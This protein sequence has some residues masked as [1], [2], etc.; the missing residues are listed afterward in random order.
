MSERLNQGHGIFDPVHHLA[1]HYVSLVELK[2]L[3]GDINERAKAPANLAALVLDGNAMP[4]DE[5]TAARVGKAYLAYRERQHLARNNNELKTW[6]S[7]DELTGER[8]AV[9][10]AWVSLLG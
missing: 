1:S 5:D 8:R 7:P 2:P 3:R 6:I 10:Q 9:T 4:S